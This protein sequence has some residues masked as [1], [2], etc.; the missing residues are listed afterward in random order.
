M[1]LANKKEV[2]KFKSQLSGR[3][4]I[5]RNSEVFTKSAEFQDAA[6]E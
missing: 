3:R 6:M 1:V 5:S 2:N 4:T